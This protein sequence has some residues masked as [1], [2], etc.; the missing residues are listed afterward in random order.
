MPSQALSDVVYDIV[1]FVLTSVLSVF[2]REVKERGAWMVPKKDPIL[3]VVAPHANQFVDPMLLYKY[4][5]RR[6]S[7]CMAQKSLERTFIGAVGRALK[8][9]ESP[10]FDHKFDPGHYA[11]N[12]NL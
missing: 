9:S 12:F 11:I 4:C 10:Q 1:V 7:F 2:F 3:F 6:I 8:S 5:P